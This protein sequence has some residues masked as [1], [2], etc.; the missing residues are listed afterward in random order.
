MLKYVAKTV[1]LESNS[2]IDEFIEYLTILRNSIP[3]E[4]Q[5][6]AQLEVE[7][8]ENGNGGIDYEIV[9]VYRREETDTE[10]TDRLEREAVN[11]VTL[12][13]SRYTTYL[14]LKKEFG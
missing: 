11:Q 14:Q 4:Y 2:T 12:S 6:I 3:Q 5:S 1:D 7:V 10:L 8:F 9:L 13:Q